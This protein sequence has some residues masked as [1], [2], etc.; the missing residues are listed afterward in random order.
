MP[1]ILLVDDDPLQAYLMTSLLR[2]QFDEVRRINDAAEA[3]RLMEQRDFAAKLSMVISGHHTL[4]IGEPAFVSE[5]QVRMPELP[6]LVLGE[7]GET[8]ADYPGEH[9]TFLPRNL[10]AEQMHSLA[11]QLLVRQNDTA[12]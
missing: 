12:A 1:A 6:I 2:P 8:G 11:R 10:V 5:L 9:V 3:L 7:E 4:G